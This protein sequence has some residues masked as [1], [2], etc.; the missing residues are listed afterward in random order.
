MFLNYKALFVHILA[1]CDEH[2]LNLGALYI[3]DI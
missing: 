1:M 3:D 2:I